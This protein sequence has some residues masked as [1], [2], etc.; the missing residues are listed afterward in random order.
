[1]H[2]KAISVVKY[3][4]LFKAQALNGINTLWRIVVAMVQVPQC[5]AS[6][7]AKGHIVQDRLI[8]MRDNKVR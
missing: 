3:T 7:V 8:S 5:A 4:Y 2:H 1:M 6:D